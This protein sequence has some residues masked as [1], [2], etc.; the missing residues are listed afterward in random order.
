MFQGPIIIN[1]IVINT[2]GIDFEFIEIAGTS[3]SD[4]S[5]FTVLEVDRFGEIDNVIALTGQS[6]PSDG[7]F[8]AASPAAE[9]QYNITADLGFADNTFTNNTNSYFLVEGFTGASGDDLDTDNDGELDNQPWAAIQ[10]Q[11]AF[12]DDDIDDNTYANPVLGPDGSFLPA[13]ALR[14]PTGL[15]GQFVEHAFSSVGTDGTPGAAN[16]TVDACGNIP[17]VINEIDSDQPGTDSTEFIELFD[18]GLGNTPL[19]GLVVVLYNGSND[20]SYNTIDLSGKSTDENG[21]FVIGSVGVPNVDTVVFTANGLQ[22]GADA[23]ALYL[24]DASTFPNGTAVTTDNLIDAIVY[25]TN[26]AEDA[27]LLV[28]LNS[29]QNQA[30]EGPSGSVESL[31]RIPNGEGGARNTANYQPII[32]TPGAINQ[33]PITNLPLTPVYD[34]QGSDFESPLVG[35]IV[36]TSGIVVGATQNGLGGYFIQDPVGDGVDATSDGIFV[37]D[38]T[39]EVQEGEFVEIVGTVAETNTQTTII[40]VLEFTQD[41]SDLLPDPVE[42]NLPVSG[43]LEFEAVEGMLVSFPQSL[44]ITEY[45]RLDGEGEI[46]LSTQRDFQFTQDNA[47]GVAEFQEFAAELALR[48]IVLDD[49]SNEDNPVPIPYPIPALSFDNFF[50]GGDLV[51][52]VTGVVGFNTNRNLYAI[53]PINTIPDS[54][55]EFTNVN[56]RPDSAPEVGGNIKV[57]SFNVL[58][59]FST[60]DGQGTCTDGLTGGTVDCRGADSDEEFARQNQKIISA[61]VALDADVV[62]LVELENNG[63]GANSSISVLVDSLNTFLG[64]EVYDFIDADLLTSTVDALGNDAIKV[65]IIY[66]SGTVKPVGRTAT[67]AGEAPFVTPNENRVPLLQAFEDL[68]SGEQFIFIVNHFKSKG[69]SGSGLDADQGDGQGQFNNRRLQASQAILDWL[70]TDPSSTGIQN[71]II[72]GDLNSYAKED[73]IQLFLNNGFTNLLDEAGNYSFLFDG[74]FGSLDYILVSNNLTEKVSGIAEWHVNADEADAFDYNLEDREG[75]ENLFSPSFIRNS[76]H[77][78]LIAGFN[79]APA[80]EIITLTTIADAKVNDATSEADKNFGAKDNMLA[81]NKPNG[82]AFE[83]YVKFELPDI[84]DVSNAKLL[85][86]GRNPNNNNIVKVV[87]FKTDSDWEELEITFNNA[88]GRQGNEVDAEDVNATPTYYEWDV[89]SLVKEQLNGEEFISFVIV[90][91]NTDRNYDRAQFNTKESDEFPPL[92]VLN[93]GAGEPTDCVPGSFDLIGDASVNNAS[94]RADDNF[95]DKGYL[96]A[97]NKPNGFGYESYL[98]FDVTGLGNSDR[99]LLRLFGNNSDSNNEVE[100]G[101]FPTIDDWSEST[102]TFNNS[103]G[104][105]GEIIASEEVNNVARYYEFDVTQEVLAQI[106][107]DGVASFVVKSLESNREY[108]RVFFNSK[109]NGEFPPLLIALCDQA[110]NTGLAFD[111]LDADR[112]VNDTDLLLS[113]FPNPATTSLGFSLSGEEQGVVQLNVLDLTGR[114]IDEQFHEKKGDQLEVGVSVGQLA[115]GMYVLRIQLGDEVLTKR[116]IKEGK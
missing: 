5:N 64:S 98:Q 109:E 10:D 29:G 97:R 21:F 68:S 28:L 39:N 58:N 16:T 17:V 18:G 86:Y 38:N 51:D 37:L 43:L 77:D 33:Q 9:A 56:P 71:I 54:T 80:E 84:N 94:S 22:N 63:Y 91:T 96:I 112:P 113:V 101:I 59:Y 73:P 26:D 47:P 82:W 44:V 14:C 57:V 3:G 66:K 15:V 49:A 12:I 65:G 52:N 13:G 81:R 45:F 88:P 99:I 106:Q 30:D 34:I 7:F 74:Q 78:P 36:R 41:G 27:G 60:I 62:G 46:T 67:L 8:V 116:F 4:L 110:N 61:L 40:N 35:S 1:E 55:F 92:L 111:E 19:T 75:L 48:R 104:V 20:Q 102:I 42:I 6:I 87:V 76:D 24:A 79:F 31:Q 90:S 105:A 114:M 53:Q 103:P 25:G 83:S 108:N 107:G 11:I 93:T 72:A 70:N 95:G 2:P 100:I 32:P 69:G 89:T 115:S 85:L 50:R 23:V